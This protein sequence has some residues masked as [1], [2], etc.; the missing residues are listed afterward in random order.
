MKKTTETKLEVPKA[1][2]LAAFGVKEE[3]AEVTAPVP[4]A[5]GQEQGTIPVSSLTITVRKTEDVRRKA[6][7]E[8]G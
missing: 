7:P 6:L 2:L 5:E 8:V 4:A 3:D 1:E